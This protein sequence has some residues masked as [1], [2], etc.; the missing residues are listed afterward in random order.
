MLIYKDANG[1]E[2]ESIETLG[3]GFC[4]GD[5]RTEAFNV[6]GHY[7][8]VLTGKGY[9]VVKFQVG[10]VP[11]NGVNGITNEALLAILIHRTKFLDTKF[12]CDEN[13]HA[14][15]HMEAALDCL[16]MRTTQRITRG[17]EGKE[18]V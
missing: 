1:V 10:P 18:E 6:E 15:Q 4:I 3:G 2:V 17:V 12:P 7:Y 13:K 11:S 8:S 14:I 5:Q 16:E 9:Q